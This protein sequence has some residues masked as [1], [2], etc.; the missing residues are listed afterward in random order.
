MFVSVLEERKNI[1]AI[2]R[3]SDILELRGVD[4]KFVL[5]GRE[6]FGFNKIISEL[7]KEKSNYTFKNI[8]DTELVLLYNLSTI[9]FFPTH[10][11]GFGLPPLEAM[12]CG[13]PVVTSNNSSLPEVVGEGGI[14]GE[15]TD[16]E[17]FANS[18]EKLLEDKNIILR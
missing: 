17:F 5:V 1:Q 16:Y 8:N 3:V 10:Y 7:E 11:E 9:F 18:I 6:G 2:I 12:K 4:L 13:I 14:M 15:A